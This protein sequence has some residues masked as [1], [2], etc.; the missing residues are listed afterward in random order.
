MAETLLFKP[1]DWPTG[2]FAER[3]WTLAGF[4]KTPGFPRVSC[5]IHRFKNT[6]S[7]VTAFFGGG[8]GR[9]ELYQRGV[10][11]IYKYH[12]SKPQVIEKIWILPAQKTV[13]GVRVY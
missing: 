2:E 12:N 1:E 7:A 3:I 8:G 4:L 5:K 6:G 11:I 10:L 9:C 13:W